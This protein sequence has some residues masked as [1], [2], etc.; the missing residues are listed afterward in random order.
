[1]FQSFYAFKYFEAVKPSCRGGWA[2]ITER[3]IK[4][5][6][7]HGV[8][9]RVPLT[10]PSGDGGEEIVFRITYSPRCSVAIGTEGVAIEGEG[11]FVYTE[12]YVGFG[13]G[14]HKGK[15]MCRW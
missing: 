14:G 5:S 1:M 9:E 8:I 3:S 15:G 11:C 13:S 6:C 4:D 7:E 12:V 2:K 10:S